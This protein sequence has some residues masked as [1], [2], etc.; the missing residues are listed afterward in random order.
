LNMWASG[1]QWHMDGFLSVLTDISSIAK[2][3]KR[4]DNWTLES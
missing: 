1:S 2:Q 3:S 4:S